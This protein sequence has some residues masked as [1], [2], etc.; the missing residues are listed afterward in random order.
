[1]ETKKKYCYFLGKLKYCPT[2]ENFEYDE[3]LKETTQIKTD[4]KKEILKAKKE[5]NQELV[6]DL[7]FN[8][9]PITICSE[10]IDYENGKEIGGTIIKSVKTISII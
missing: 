3:I 2:D 6:N 9:N 1:M 4:I 8:Y 7:L 10:I 5:N